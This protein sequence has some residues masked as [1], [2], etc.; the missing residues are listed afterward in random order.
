MA[1]PDMAPSTIKVRQVV[2]KGRVY[3]RSE[4]VANL[5]YELA[6]TEDIDVQQRLEVVAK[7]FKEK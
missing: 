5:L 4:D 1:K 6:S 2:L 3:V 7:Q